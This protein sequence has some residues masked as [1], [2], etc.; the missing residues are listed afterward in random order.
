MDIHAYNRAAWNKRVATGNKW[1]I[2]VGP[3]AI[4]SA[5]AGRVEFLLTPTRFVPARWLPPLAGCKVLCLA[6]GG[7]QQGPLFAAAG[8]HV[9]AFDL[10]PRQLEQDRPTAQR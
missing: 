3:G 6:S 4:A 7:G 9:T 10:S 8:A 1:T 2:P 5:R